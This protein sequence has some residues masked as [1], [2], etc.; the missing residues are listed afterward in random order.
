MTPDQD[1][2]NPVRSWNGLQDTTPCCRPH[3][4]ILAEKLT[5]H[6]GSTPAFEGVSWSI[7]KG[8]LTA[9][10]G[11]SGCGKTSFLSCVNRLTDLIPH[12][13]LTGSLSLGDTDIL[14]HSTNVLHLRRRVGMIFQQPTPFPLSIRKN[15]EIPL[16]EYG[17][18]DRHLLTH[19]LETSLQAVGLW[20]E[21]K[22]RLDSSAQ[23]L[24]GGQQQRLCIARTLALSP[25]VLL[26]DEPCSAL[27]PISS[28]VVEDLIHNLRG[29][30]TILM[31]THNLAQARRIADYVGMFWAQSGSGQLIEQ[32][33]TSQIF[34]DPQ[35]PVTAAY[36]QGSRG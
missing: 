5:L 31:V 6:Y 35:H 20:D 16:R 1:A 17:I 3:P 8:C 27:D 15:L 36:I 4:L 22:D 26:L 25:E 24:S 19:H 10:V 21:V 18:K 14:S 7:N 33:P 11:P 29:Q 32:G 34:E 30:F 9:L 28:G 2:E 23:R 13:H 12:S